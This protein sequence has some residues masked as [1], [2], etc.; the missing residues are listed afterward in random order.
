MP[1][2]APARL[3]ALSEKALVRLVWDPVPAADLAGYAIF[4]AEG[5]AAPA[6]WNKELVKD[7]FAADDTVQPGHRYRYTVRAVDTSGNMSAPSPEAV[8]E[9]F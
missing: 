6:R 8:A 5:N 9:P 7:S 3:D 4:R 2:P 1:P